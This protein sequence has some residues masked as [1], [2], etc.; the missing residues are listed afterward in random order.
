MLVP[1]VVTVF[2]MG[3]EDYVDLSPLAGH[4]AIFLARALGILGYRRGQ[5][6]K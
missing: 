4:K 2:T 1:K 5:K 6:Y 3:Y